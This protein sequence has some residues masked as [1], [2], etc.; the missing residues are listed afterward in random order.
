MTGKNYSTMFIRSP[1]GTPE[2]PKARYFP[3][4]YIYPLEVCTPHALLLLPLSPSA[5]YQ[6]AAPTSWNPGDLMP[7]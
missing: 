5:A 1:A 7:H 4:F 3:V 2:I 6:H